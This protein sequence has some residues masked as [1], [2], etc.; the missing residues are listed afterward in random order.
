MSDT[1]AE[2]EPE[3]AATQA[4]QNVVDEVT[5]WDYSAEK[6]TI[7]SRLDEGLEQAQVTV[8]G[9]ERARLVEEIDDV[10]QDETRGAPDVEAARPADG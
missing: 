3:D 1:P 7:A 2:Q 4:A 10:K 6:D 8:D 9:D 5:S